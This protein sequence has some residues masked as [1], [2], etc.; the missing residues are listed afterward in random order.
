MYSP[1]N[2]SS[3][4]TKPLLSFLLI[5]LTCLL[6][7]AG[8]LRSDYYM[9]DFMFVVDAKEE[10]PPDRYYTVPVLGAL[11]GPSRPG[12]KEVSIFEIIPT[13]FWL[14]TDRLVAD[15]ISGSWAYHFWNI[16][17]HV[18][19]SCAAFLAGRELLQ[20]IGVFRDEKLCH[21]AALLAALLFACHP[22]CSEP[23]NYAKCLNHIS[24]AFF[25]LLAIWLGC[26]WLRTGDRKAAGW[27]A[28]SLFFATFSYMPGLA[29]SLAWFGLIAVAYKSG[30]SPVGRFQFSG[31]LKLAAGLLAAAGVA[32]YGNA[33]V[34]Q[35]THWSS[36]RMAHILTQGRVFWDY[37]RLSVFPAGLCSDHQLPWSVPGKDGA[38]VVSLTLLALMV[39]ALFTGAWKLR[40]P[41]ARGLCLIT[42]LA[43]T[44]LLMRFLYINAEV[45]VE[46]R[47]YP[48]LP[49]LMLVPAV[50][51]TAILTNLPRVHC[52]LAA[53]LILTFCGLSMQRTQVWSN[54]EE[55]LAD[56]LQK[57]P[58]HQRART[59]LQAY[60]GANGNPVGVIRLHQE[61]QTVIPR[62]HAL[63]AQNP[64]RQFDMKETP[65]A[66]I[67]S[68]QWMIYAIAEKDGS[69][70]ALEWAMKIIPAFETQF[71]HYFRGDLSLQDPH[72]LPNAWPLLMARNT[73][74][75]HAREID[76]ARSGKQGDS[77]PD[78]RN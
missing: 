19:T 2:A 39:V 5:A 58:L 69:K 47:T 67:H 16:L 43:V 65:M 56:V 53:L 8:A 33:L 46:Y 13:A 3:Q 34:S 57:Y 31:R 76:A 9:D 78:S 51:L 41:L 25:G 63:N 60:Y 36:S 30:G 45:M 10:A 26:R 24:E 49:W 77:A 62:L 17:F 20:T 15:P 37:L 1:A 23:V 35:Q 28:A 6:A 14:L 42:L 7:F 52:G 38:A 21:R 74:R 55:L 64:S 71:P 18:L 44:P 59:Q 22:L 32:V 27:A 66:L 29:I 72:R 73:V 40:Q 50:L 11:T 4:A 12:A 48:A 70:P 61:I 75:D 54:R 68:S